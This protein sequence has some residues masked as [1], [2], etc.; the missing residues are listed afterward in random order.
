MNTRKK[1]GFHNLF[2]FIFLFLILLVSSVSATYVND[3]GEFGDDISNR[4]WV[5]D[6]SGIWDNVS[7]IDVALEG[8]GIQTL[9]IDLDN[10]G[11]KEIIS[12]DGK[13][14][15]IYE[16]SETGLSLL[17]DRDMTKSLDGQFTVLIHDN[18][19]NPYI[20]GSWDNNITVL[21]WA[22]N[23]LEVV[24][25]N[26]N[27]TAEIKTGTRC[28][29]WSG[30]N[31]CYFGGST[32]TNC[33]IVEYSV[34]TNDFQEIAIGGNVDCFELGSTKGERKNVPLIFDIDKDSKLEL[35]A[36]YDLDQDGNEGFFIY[37]IESTSIQ[38]KKDDI[39]TAGGKINQL[40]VT[41]I[42][43]N[44]DE[45]VSCLESCRDNWLTFAN[46]IYYYGC[47]LTC[48]Y[49][50]WRSGYGGG[51]SEL[52]LSYRRTTGSAKNSYLRTYSSNCALTNN[53]NM[54]A[55]P[56]ADYE[57]FSSNVLFQDFVGDSDWEY[58]QVN[59]LD[60]T[61]TDNGFVR[62][63][64]VNPVTFNKIYEFESTFQDY[65][66]IYGDE[67]SIVVG[68]NMDTDNKMEIITA[69]GIILDLTSNN[70]INTLP[71]G[72]N[73]ATNVE[74]IPMVA[75]VNNDQNLDVITI[76]LD[77][78][79]V[80]TSTYIN[81][82]PSLNRVRMDSTNPVCLGQSLSISASEQLN[83]YMNDGSED[84]ERLIIIYEN[85]S[86]SFGDWSLSNPTIQYDTSSTG[87][88]NL[89]VYLEDEFNVGDRTQK[90]DNFKIIVS[91][92][93][94]ICSYVGIGVT[95]S[96]IS[97]DDEL[98][99]QTGVDAFIEGFGVESSDTLKL[100]LFVVFLIAVNLALV[101]NFFMHSQGLVSGVVLAV[102]N[103][104]F[105]AI[106]I[107]MGIIPA[108]L[109]VVATISIIGIAV[110]VIFSKRG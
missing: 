94:N 34:L 77:Y 11:N 48:T 97:E 33:S 106:G 39:D 9:V 105:F 108:W 73:W 17:N 87:T 25:Y 41:N 75:D 66:T 15:Q 64:C 26:D 16:Y 32:P 28:I 29:N 70:S 100:I 8:L 2:I 56:S 52:L 85:G 35:I 98:E 95:T 74:G 42:D 19:T 86:Q 101:T 60:Y 93:E 91:S 57:T 102:A 3:W 54:Y 7:I 38:C 110:I 69:G 63:T 49:N 50:L 18:F 96:D 78:L 82:I 37:D 31:A 22:N 59:G 5:A 46:P 40:H 68:A 88:F 107:T 44:M 24:Q 23:E 92:N 79:L 62:I 30:K 1:I 65:E 36:Y 72:S 90:I 6:E 104:L 12:H 99:F 61:L 21:K 67:R 109:P 81:E 71:F 51:S 53:I 83:D 4:Q 27:V 47:P 80:A 43:A 14:L 10:D 13:F 55:T 76:K 20:I 84:E 89:D 58:C 45:Y 103:I